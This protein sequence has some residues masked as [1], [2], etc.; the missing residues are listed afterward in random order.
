MASHLILS[1][2]RLLFREALR[3]CE[4]D[5]L[6][7]RAETRQLL[8]LLGSMAGLYFPGLSHAS[9]GKGIDSAPCTL[10][11]PDIAGTATPDINAE[12]LVQLR[13]FGG[14]N[15]DGVPALVSHRPSDCQISRHG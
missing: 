5:G 11:V 3:S 14:T 12:M 15:L 13:V 9:T 2:E 8:A 7:T 10:P 4:A 1:D 6:K